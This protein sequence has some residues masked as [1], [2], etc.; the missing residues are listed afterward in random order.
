[1]IMKKF[2]IYLICCVFIIPTAIVLA[3]VQSLVREYTYQASELDSK[4]SS[5]TIA[6]EQVKRELLE[7]FGTYVEATS[8]VQDAQIQKDEII[9]LTAGVVQTKILDEKWD[10]KEY[11]LQAEVSAD[12]DEVAAAIDKMK[13]DQQ[14]SQE[15][16]ESQAEK[17]AALQEVERLKAELAQS[18]ADKEK[19][20]QYNQAV[21]QIQASDSFEQGTA[22]NVAGDY[23]G[24]AKAYDRVII[25]RPEDPKAY[26]GRSVV[27]INLGNYDRAT[28]DL[29]RAM[30]IRPA[31]TEIYFQRASVYK[32][33]SETRIATRPYPGRPYPGVTRPPVRPIGKEDPLQRYLDRKQTEHKF[34]KVNNFQ[35]RPRPLVK[36]DVRP[37]QP[38]PVM[39]TKDRPMVQQPLR[40]GVHPQQVEKR[41]FVQ[42]RDQRVEKGS[43]MVRQ[44]LKQEVRKPIMPPPGQQR[45]EKRPPVVQPKREVRAP[46]AP[47]PAQQQ[48]VVKTPKQIKEEEEKAH[49][50]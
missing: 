16:A 32:H 10:G 47:K 3:E 13:N 33:I 19:L 34:V 28:R 23:D 49:H 35:P 21:T 41:P 6:L 5:R 27:Y 4:S 14:L 25:L 8:V 18:N 30:V 2:I 38:R 42:P 9:A 39:Q 22:M 15:L 12:P 43:P 26:F 1:M 37:V 11:W 29:D 45:V 36:R 20:A 24:A 17:D 46:I 31:N 44:P 50:R 7:E 48:K 40:P